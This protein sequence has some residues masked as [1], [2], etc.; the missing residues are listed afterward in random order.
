MNILLMNQLKRKLGLTNKEISDLTGISVSLISKLFA[1]H[2]SA[3]SK[4][5]AI[6][7]S[8]VLHCEIED[9][10]DDGFN[11][12]VKEEEI[13]DLII[14]NYGSINNFAKE[15]DI[16]A[17]T[18]NRILKEG[19]ETATFG[20]LSI[21]FKK[22]NLSLDTLKPKK[23][24]FNLVEKALINCFRKLNKKGQE[25]I[26]DYIEDIIKIEEYSILYTDKDR[27]LKEGISLNTNTSDDKIKNIVK[28]Y[29]VHTRRARNDNQDD[30]KE[31]ELMNEDFKQMIKL[32]NNL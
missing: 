19:I 21:I 12:N 23:R 25:K 24:E 13:R 32:K 2:L 3:I 27:V 30:D 11:L 28:D 10:F 31:Q 20:K 7:I 6:K 8:N 5:N 14:K 18:I 26:F 22:L 29:M 15:I 16:P 9:I 17:S 4:T 1:G